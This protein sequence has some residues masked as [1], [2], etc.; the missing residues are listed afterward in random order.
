MIGQG[1]G[2][3]VG[4]VSEIDGE[5]NRGD[6][7]SGVDCEKGGSVILNGPVKI[8]VTTATME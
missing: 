4:N 6:G 3:V 5:C 8:V 1:N 7:Q 2:R